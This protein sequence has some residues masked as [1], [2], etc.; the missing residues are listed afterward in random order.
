MENEILNKIL[1]KLEQLEQKVDHGLNSLGGEVGSLRGEV[2]SLRG[3]VGSLQSEVGLLRSDMNE[4]FEKVDATLVT[5]QESVD[6]I[7]VSQQ[8]NIV[9]VI[10]LMD[11]KLEDTAKKSDIDS[12]RQDIEFTVKE[13]SLFKLELDRLKRNAYE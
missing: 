12:L 2:G 6:R 1:D 10:R 7:E 5:L 4:R 11:Q 8:E 9:S 13:N 3:E